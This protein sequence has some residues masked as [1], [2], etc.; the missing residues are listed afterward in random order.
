MLRI[1][2]PYA[3]KLYLTP[4]QFPK[5]LTPQMLSEMSKSLG[6][7]TRV[8]NNAS[9]AYKT[10]LSESDDGEVVLVTGSLYLVG[11][12]YRHLKNIAPPVPDGSI[13]DRI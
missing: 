7:S 12:I 4:L 6:N 2:Q 5:S 9:E 1:L 11:E 3:E 10:A 13:D 8:F